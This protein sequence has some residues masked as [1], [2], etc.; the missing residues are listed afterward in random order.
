MTKPQDETEYL[1]SSPENAKQLEE[2]MQQLAHPEKRGCVVR[3]L[4]EL[5]AM[6][7]E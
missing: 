6:A 1:L 7:K 4:E 3:T 5:E 2:S